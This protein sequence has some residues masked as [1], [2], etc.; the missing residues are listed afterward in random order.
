MTCCSINTWFLATTAFVIL[1]VVA[2]E[3]FNSYDFHRDEDFASVCGA[4]FLSPSCVCVLQRRVCVVFCF[5]MDKQAFDAALMEAVADG[6]VGRIMDKHGIP[7]STRVQD[8]S[9]SK[10]WPDV[11]KSAFMDKRTTF[12]NVFD[13]GSIRVCAIRTR[14]GTRG[15]Y[16][17]GN[18]SGTGP[19]IEAEIAK[20]IGKRYGYSGTLKVEYVWLKSREDLFPS[21]NDGKCEYTY[22]LMSVGGFTSGIRR[23]EKWRPSCSVVGDKATLYVKD[24]LNV[25]SFQDFQNMFTRPR[26]GCIDIATLQFCPQ[27]IIDSQCSPFQSDEDAYAALQ[28]GEIDTFLG[29]TLA[30]TF[31]DIKNLT[32]PYFISRSAWFRKEKTPDEKVVEED[33]LLEFMTGNEALAL[34]YEVALNTMCQQTVTE[35]IFNRFGINRFDS[36]VCHKYSEV[37]AYFHSCVCIC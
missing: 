32:T 21:L 8:C 27:L 4:L 25:S 3:Q 13:R 35:R 10:D 20:R 34:T 7:S 31:P 2:K 6:T 22:P 1:V 11:N 17:K 19:E 14:G 28:R 5:L 15:N 24:S 33:E 37:Y 29:S 12:S 26:I 9:V 23:A 30:M 16:V 18:V 36:L